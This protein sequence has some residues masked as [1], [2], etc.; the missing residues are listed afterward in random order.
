MGNTGLKT[1]ILFALAWFGCGA[2]VG[3]AMMDLQLQ[4]PKPKAFPEGYGR[5]PVQYF[6][7]TNANDYRFD[8]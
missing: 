1:W 3:L 4:K 5:S 8:I 2:L 6:E 7:P